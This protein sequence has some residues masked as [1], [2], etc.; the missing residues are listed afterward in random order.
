MAYSLGNLISSQRDPYTD[1]GLLLQLEFTK[2][3]QGTRVSAVRYEPVWRWIDTQPNGHQ[4]FLVI[5]E[6]KAADPEVGLSLNQQR[7][8][9]A[10]IS[11]IR[12]KLNPSNPRANAFLLPLQEDFQ[13]FHATQAKG[14]EMNGWSAPE[15][16]VKR[17]MLPWW[18]RWMRLF[19]DFVRQGKSPNQNNFLNF[20]EKTQCWLHAK[21]R[22]KTGDAKDVISLGAFLKRWLELWGCRANAQKQ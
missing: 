18:V 17:S 12:E 16:S 9:I 4:R 15:D 14:I 3:P 7:Q 6:S 20:K 21:E 22:D 8:V 5:P 19:V 10:S 2:D 13:R 1:V 11:R